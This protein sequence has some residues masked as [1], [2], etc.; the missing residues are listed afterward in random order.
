L[1]RAEKASFPVTVMCNALGVKRGSYYAWER[2]PH[3]DR[4]CAEEELVV[5]IRDVFRRSRGTYGSPRVHA[6]LNET[7]VE[8][9]RHRVARLMHEHGLQARRPKRYRHTTDSEHSLPVAPNLLE[10][11]FDAEAPNRVWVADLTCLWTHEGWLY[12]A[13]VLDLFSRRVV[14]WAMDDNMRKELPLRALEMAIGQ[15]QPA[16]GLVHHSDRGSQYASAAYRAAL[17]TAGAVCSM[18]RRGDCYD[19]AVAE[20]FFSTLEAELE[21]RCR[22][23]TLEAA[24]LAVFD[25][26]E[27]FYNTRRR[28]SY[29]GKISPAAYEKATQEAKSVAA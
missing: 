10:R 3:E 18:S 7:G 14:G 20:S 12:L 1:I 17:D 2:R 28:H 5:H 6:E 26:I 24:R 4:D 19:N 22:W 11:R 9:G 27:A 13:A 15:R 21:G 29:L 23:E 25:Y 8:V 16:V